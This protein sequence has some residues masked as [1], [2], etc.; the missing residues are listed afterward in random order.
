MDQSECM[1]PQLLISVSCLFRLIE[2]DGTESM[3][4]STIND[5]NTLAIK[6]LNPLQQIP[7]QVLKILLCMQI[8]PRVVYIVV[9]FHIMSHDIYSSH[10][11]FL[12][13]RLHIFFHKSL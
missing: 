3:L 10:E 4:L 9:R 5:T 6:C 7:C 13:L 11:L 2:L 12:R 8:S 1:D